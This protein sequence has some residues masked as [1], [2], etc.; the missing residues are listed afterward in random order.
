[1]DTLSMVPPNNQIRLADKSGPPHRRTSSGSGALR[2]LADTED[3]LTVLWEAEDGLPAVRLA[4]QTP[5][6]VI[7]MD[8]RMPGLTA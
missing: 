3:D 5:P 1:M 7:L 2:V 6:D 4:R 8:I